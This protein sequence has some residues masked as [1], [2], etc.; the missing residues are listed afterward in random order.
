MMFDD[1]GAHCLLCSTDMKSKPHVIRNHFKDFH[2]DLMLKCDKCDHRTMSKSALNMHRLNYH[3]D[4]TFP[5]D[6]CHESWP[7]K[8]QLEHHI[9]MKHTDTKFRPYQCHIC[10]KRSMDKAGHL[11]H[12]EIHEEVRIPKPRKDCE[13]CGTNMLASTMPKHMAAQHG[14]GEYLCK[15]CRR[16]FHSQKTLDY[17]YQ[18]THVKTPCDECGQFFSST[19]MTPHKLQHHTPDHLKP[20]LCKIC[21]PP[22]GFIS[23]SKYR[24]HVNTHTGATPF[25]CDFCSRTFRDGSNKF[26]HMRQVHKGQY[27]S[28][29]EK[30]AREGEQT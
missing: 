6:M 7:L 27:L 8:S 22:K 29:K 28:R 13:I 15:E 11:A 26:K 4:K 19:R 3:S 24:M 14:V 20:F 12:L 17:H 2:K 23:A 1:N 5:C 9:K 21:D 16:L 25:G 10:G 18:T 30:K